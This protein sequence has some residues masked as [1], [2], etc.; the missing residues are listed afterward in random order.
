MKSPFPGMDPFLELHWGDVHQTLIVYAR[1]VLQPRLPD[2]LLARIEE[3]VYVESSQSGRS[4]RIVPDLRVSESYRQSAEPPSEFR[5]NAIADAE[6]IVF[7]M[8][9]LEV[10]ES[11][12]TICEAEGGAVITIIEFLSP[13]NKRPGP[14]QLKYRE[15]QT[16]AL[17]SAASLVEIDLVRSGERVL[18]LPTPEI[19][20]PHRDDY[21]ACISPGWRR[22]RRELY[23]MPLRRRLP[24]IPIPLRQHESP[25][26]LDLQRLIDQAYAAGR[27]HKLDYS[28]ALNPTLPAADAAWALELAQSAPHHPT[29]V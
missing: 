6:P 17:Q 5:E 7:E 25:V 28:A 8:D 11:F 19:P 13:A 23:T 27:Y 20:A 10:S 16:E 2:D 18:A 29:A 21:L 26:S 22:N 9:E 1:D 14:G 24:N 4:R 15:K 12:I 3:R